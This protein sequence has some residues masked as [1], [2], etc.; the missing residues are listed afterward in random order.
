MIPGIE[1]S[2]EGDDEEIHLL[3]YYLN[4]DD[5]ALVDALRAQHT[6]RQERTRAILERL[7]VLGAPVTWEAVQF[8]ASGEAISRPH[9]ARALVEA[10]HV[11]DVNSAF[12]RYLRVGKPAYVAGKWFGL[13]QAIDLIHQAGG[14]AVLA[15]PG[16]L[17]DPERWAA[18]PGLDGLEIMHP[19]HKSSM[20]AN[21]RGWARQKGL[22]MTGGSDFHRPQDALGSQ[23][24]P[25]DTLYRLRQCAARYRPDNP[26]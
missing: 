4:P 5:P 14:V 16:V 21:L 23:S 10:G 24:L 11:N 3:G 22:I 8:H 18:H 25:P 17:R 15:H 9:V 20:R 2:C 1:M 13:T 12:D 7:S 19:A 26:G 6:R